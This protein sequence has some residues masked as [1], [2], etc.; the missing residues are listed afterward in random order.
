MLKWQELSFVS[1]FRLMHPILIELCIVR[2]G[3]KFVHF[4]Q[5]LKLWIGDLEF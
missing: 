5:Y 1:F 4:V 3:G 2:I